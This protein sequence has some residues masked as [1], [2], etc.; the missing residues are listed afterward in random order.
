[1]HPPILSRRDLLRY[2]LGTAAGLALAGASLPAWAGGDEPARP[3]RIAAK[4]KSVIQVWLWGGPCHLDTF[5][6]KPTAGRDYSGPLT[7]PVQT[8]VDGVKIGQHLPLLAKLADRYALLRGLTHGNNGHETAAYLVQTGRKAGP[9]VHPGIGA[10]VAYART[11]AGHQGMLP[12]YI[13][14]TSQQGRFSESGYLGAKYKPFATGGDPSKDPFTVE[15]IVARGI[16]EERQRDRRALLAELDRI[17]DET[18]GGEAAGAIDRGREQAYEMIL[19]KAGKVFDLSQEKADLR[20]R[21]GRTR[22]GQSCLCARRLVEA[23]V[24]YV[25]INHQGWDTHKS[26]F[27]EMGRKLPE[28]DKGLTALLTDLSERGLLD[29]TIVWV[30]GEFGRT[31]KIDWAEPW[32]G[33]RGH[34]GKAFSALV[35][36]GGFKGGRV[37]GATDPRGETVIERPIWPWDLLGTMYALLGIDGA[38]KLPHPQGLDTRVSPLGTDEIL[39]KETGGLLTEIV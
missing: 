11:Q 19:G 33:G 29:S 17:G 28:L 9:I 12:P 20:D 27:E 37:V 2:S 36:G 1:M 39:A 6:P 22:F 38:M 10:I 13:A 31:P 3:P 25:T 4:A 21:Y 8:V 15:G 26:H 34:H 14:L 16:S 30:G 7:N 24:P 23:G 35:A 18:G 5:D 32:N